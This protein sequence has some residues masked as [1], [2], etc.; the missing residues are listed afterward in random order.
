VRDARTVH[1]EAV[2]LPALLLGARAAP[3]AGDA[4]G[5]RA[6]LAEAQTAIGHYRPLPLQLELASAE[7]AILPPSEAVATYDTRAQARSRHFPGY[8]RAARAARA[9]RQVLERA[10]DADGARAAGA[11]AQSARA[12]LERNTPEHARAALV[13]GG[14]AAPKQGDNHEPGTPVRRGRRDAATRTRRSTPQLSTLREQQERLFEQMQSGQQRFKQLARS[15]WRVQEDERR[16]LARELH[17]GIGQNLTALKHQLDAVALQVQGDARAA[18]ARAGRARALRRTLEDT[19]ALS[20]LLRPQILDDLG[21]EAALRWLAAQHGRERGFQTEVDV[22]D[23]PEPLDPELSTLVLPRRAGRARQRRAPREG[24]PRAD[25]AER[26]EHGAQ[27]LVADDGV[28]C[29]TRRRVRAQLA[30]ARAPG[31]AATRERV[32]LFG[33]RLQFISEPGTGTQ[34][35]VH[36]PLNGNRV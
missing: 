14:A 6:T 35:R 2:A 10:G 24:A 4:T 17:D 36:L 1:S 12:E 29:D 25:P 8:G 18:P 33:G 3:K 11:R 31:W 7:L 26:R 13:A 34:L 5:A 30:P 20:R 21:L 27:L 23:L 22:V 9:G 28:G 19:R 15:V 16:R 32:A